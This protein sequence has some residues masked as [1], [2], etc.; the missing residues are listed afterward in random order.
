MTKPPLTLLFFPD[1]LPWE[2]EG[3]QPLAD[4]LSEAFE[5]RRVDLLTDRLAMRGAQNR[6]AFWLLAHHWEDALRWARRTPGTR[7]YISVLSQ[8]P[9]A[10]LFPALIFQKFKRLPSNVR[11]VAHSPLSF[12]FLCEIRRLPTDRVVYLPLPVK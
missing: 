7:V 11:F 5:V 8:P 2:Q 12:R 4:C 10:S 9:P 1:L 3:L 6:G